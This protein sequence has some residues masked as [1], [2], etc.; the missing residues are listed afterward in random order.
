[1]QQQ[2]NEEWRVSSADETDPYAPILIAHGRRTVA[3]VWLDDAPVADFNAKQ[4]AYA[5]RIVA[6]L[7]A[8]GGMSD[9]SVKLAAD[10]DL[11]VKALRHQTQNRMLVEALNT[12]R[13]YLG[14]LPNGGPALVGLCI[15]IDDALSGGAS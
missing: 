2:M 13:D 5:A 7:N 10:K 14:D 11:F 1:M 9:E 3:S 4:H 12:A 6:C 15:M 8:C